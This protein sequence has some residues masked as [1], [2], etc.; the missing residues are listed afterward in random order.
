MCQRTKSA[1]RLIQRST[2]TRTQIGSAD[3]HQLANFAKVWIGYADMHA[4]G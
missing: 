2:S 1:S 4:I 3:V